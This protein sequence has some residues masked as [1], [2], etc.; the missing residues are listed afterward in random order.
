MNVSASSIAV[1]ICA[2]TEAR[3][4]ALCDC[5]ESLQAQTYLPGEIILVIDHNRTLY[6]RA[7]QTFSDITVVE[8]N[9]AQGLSGARNTG[10]RLSKSPVVAFI[11]DDAV[12]ER[13]WALAIANAFKDASVM[14]V[15]GRIDPFW[16][17]QIP[18]WMPSEFL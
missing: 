17:S 16:E 12:A 10:I 15:G 6:E 11:D 2:Y 14:A 18:R 5:V 9:Q 8:N 1:V 3:F 13:H 7:R 4:A